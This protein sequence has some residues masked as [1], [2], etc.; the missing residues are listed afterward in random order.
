MRAKSSKQRCP[1]LCIL[2]IRTDV[3]RYV[4]ARSHW[5]FQIKTLKKSTISRSRGRSVFFPFQKKKFANK[6]E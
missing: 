5:N 1:A 4:K 6:I 2:W 3:T